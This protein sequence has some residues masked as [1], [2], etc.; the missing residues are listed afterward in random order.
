MAD[1]A[2]EAL[3]FVPGSQ[4]QHPGGFAGNE[5]AYQHQTSDFMAAGA[6]KGAGAAT[7][8][9][10]GASGNDAEIV[11][12]AEL[13]AMLAEIHMPMRI[14]VRASEAPASESNP[15]Y[16]AE[17]LAVDKLNSRMQL[18]YQYFGDKTPFW[19]SVAS[20]RLWRGQYP[21]SETEW[22]NLGSVRNFLLGWQQDGEQAYN[23]SP[24]RQP[25]S[26]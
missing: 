20:A 7:V 9:A 3:G 1:T 22:T 16:R 5:A 8:V 10:A 11:T 25:A 13:E 23:A 14:M 17:V 12:G 4:A 15:Y 18:R 26:P 19:V 2:L 21:L 24:P 6:L